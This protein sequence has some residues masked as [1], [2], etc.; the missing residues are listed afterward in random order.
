MEVSPEGVGVTVAPGPRADKRTRDNETNKR[1]PTMRPKGKLFALLA[2][3]GAIGLVTASGAFTTVE[4]QRTADIDV[5]GDSS[6]LVAIQENTSAGNG[7]YLQGDGEEAQLEFNSSSAV[8][9]DGINQN[10]ESNVEDVCTITNQGSQAGA[11]NIS[12]TGASNGEH[13][14]FYTLDIDASQ[15]NGAG[16]TGGDLISSTDG[17]TDDIIDLTGEARTGGDPTRLDGSGNYVVLDPGEQVTVSLFIDTT[18]DDLSE[19]EEL[20]NEITIRA[21]ADAAPSETS[22]NGGQIGTGSS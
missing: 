15:T 6:A 8:S 20:V 7:D 14:A 16:F 9:G 5:A 11:V 18:A 21:S 22:N 13:V 19:S 1:N 12:K 2:V 4:A 10:A 17:G 3:F